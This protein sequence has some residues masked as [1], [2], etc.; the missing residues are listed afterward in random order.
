MMMPPDGSCHREP[1]APAR[2]DT[3][4]S[5][6]MPVHQGGPRL[7]KVLAALSRSDLPGVSRELIVVDDASTDG[8]AGI[9]AGYADV[10]IRLTERPRGPAYARNRGAEVA[11]G[12]LIAFVDADVLV[13]PQALRRM[14]DTLERDPG[15]AAVVGAYD[16]T[17]ESGGVL[18]DYRNLLR[19]IEHRT[20]SGDTNI[21]SADLALVRRDAFMLAGMFDEW[22]FP[23]P[24]VEALELG[25]RFRALGYRLERRNDATATHLKIWTLWDWIRVDLIDR[26]VSVARLRRYPQYR[27]RAER[28]YLATRLDAVLAWTATGAL[29]AALLATS[30]TVAAVGAAALVALVMH[31]A[32]LFLALGRA[33]GIAFAAAAVPLHLV[34]CGV[35][36]AASAVGRALYHA[37]GEP[38]PD[39]VV[40]AF[41]EVGLRTWPPVPLPRELQRR[42]STDNGRA[43]RSAVG[44]LGITQE[45]R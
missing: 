42:P 32:R 34:T 12:S 33:R 7:R 15:V 19:H 29:F 23:R 24:Q 36:G 44:R 28:L 11:R 4:L 10:V 43:P 8:S 41:A 38:Q 39:P 2:A 9:A 3:L 22:R 40:Q 18:S 45:A 17:L 20:S 21:M 26:V 6:V 1:G 37:V 27:A 16:G 25:D 5:I 30:A 31:N 14:I 13:D 35:Y